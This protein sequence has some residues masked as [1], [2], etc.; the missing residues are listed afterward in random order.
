MKPNYLRWAGLTAIL[1]VALLYL[2][3]L[4]TG[5]RAR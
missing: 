2:F 4:D 3:T 5:L 1:A